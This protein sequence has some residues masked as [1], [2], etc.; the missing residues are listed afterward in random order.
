MLFIKN[1]WPICLWY[2]NSQHKKVHDL[3]RHSSSDPSALQAL[4]TFL[5]YPTPTPQNPSTAVY[6]QGPQFLSLTSG[7]ATNLESYVVNVLENLHRH[8]VQSM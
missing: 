6:L 4:A 5:V 8:M 7:K 3:T 2:L 1:M